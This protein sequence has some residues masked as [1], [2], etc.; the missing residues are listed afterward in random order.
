M[1]K[2]KKPIFLGAV[3][4]LLIVVVV[5]FNAASLSNPVDPEAADRLR[6]A[7]EADRKKNEPAPQPAKEPA[8]LS[9][10]P[11]IE[12]A[13]DDKGV[14]TKAAGFSALQKGDNLVKR[15]REIHRKAKTPANSSVVAQGQWYT[16]QSG[17]GK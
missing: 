9:S 13:N 10:A 11:M 5:A 4:I 1:K 12:D 7:E 6:A 15:G 17:S 3:L 2:R 14:G 8:T 16:Q